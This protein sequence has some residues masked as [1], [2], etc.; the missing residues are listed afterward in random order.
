[1]EKEKNSTKF[2]VLIGVLTALLIALG[3]YTV[4]LYND[5]KNT[6]ANLE[7][8]KTLYTLKVQ[9]LAKARMSTD[10]PQRGHGVQALA[11]P[12]QLPQDLRRLP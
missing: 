8:Q 7:T 12:Y 10:T 5:S 2:K 1:M 4:S 11:H 9:Y 3:V 6:V